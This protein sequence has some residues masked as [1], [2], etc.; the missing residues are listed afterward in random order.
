VV[1]SAEAL[2]M[3]NYNRRSAAVLEISRQIEIATWIF[4]G[5]QP[6]D[7]ALRLLDRATNH[8]SELFD[9]A[10]GNAASAR[11][12]VLTFELLNRC[13]CSVV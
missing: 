12:I 13:A 8:S 4:E 5:A 2:L 6:F 1:F 3:P 9:Q 11:Q 7:A 10:I